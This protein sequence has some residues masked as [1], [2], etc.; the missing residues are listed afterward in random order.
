MMNK[1]L[2]IG[3][4]FLLTG[5]FV[6]QSKYDAQYETMLT[7]QIQNEKFLE[8]LAQYSNDAVI[9]K[10]SLQ[11]E[12]AK[13]DELRYQLE[14]IK[15][16][17]NKEKDKRSL[18]EKENQELK[19]TLAE[20]E[21]QEASRLANEKPQDEKN[22][23]LKNENAKIVQENKALKT[24]I[25]S[26][27][28]E[29]SDLK[30]R[31]EKLIS[32]NESEAVKKITQA[33]EQVSLYS[34]AMIER[35]PSTGVDSETMKL[36]D[37]YYSYLRQGDL[38]KALLLR[39]D[40]VN[41]KAFLTAYKNIFLIKPY[42]FGPGESQSEIKFLVDFSPKKNEVRTYRLIYSAENGKLFQS[43]SWALQ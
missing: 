39:G 12:E 43:A 3:T 13:Y 33:E 37:E 17:G 9:L 8:Q 26:L 23:K 24:K 31:V 28:K 20:S 6:S 4:S 29:I 5:C 27:E 36:I 2:V 19:E 40:S 35:L 38:E 16:Q 25:A 11:E 14:G 21:K 41:R 32:E 34:S 1:L 22:N 10:K 15:T 18:L 30:S 7:I 42:G